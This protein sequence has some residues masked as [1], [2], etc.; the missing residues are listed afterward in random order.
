MAIDAAQDEGAIAAAIA[1]PNFWPL[2]IY[3]AVDRLR[4]PGAA[5]VALGGVRH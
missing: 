3:V 2:M 4:R 5:S 1:G